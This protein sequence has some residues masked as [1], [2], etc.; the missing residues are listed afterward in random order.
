MDYLR[1]LGS[2]AVSTLVQKSGLN[3]PFTLGAKVA[4]FDTIYTLYDGTKRDDG[5]PVSIF[6]YE[7]SGRNTRALAQNAL[8]KL[9]TT[10]HPDV[11]KFMDVVETDSTIHIM[12]ERVRPLQ[13]ALSSW[14]TKTEQERQDWLLW[15]LHRVSVAL[16]FLNDP[17][18]STH[19]A[20]NTNAIFISP[21]GEW[22]LGG[23][24]LLSNPKDDAAV[25]YTSAS[26]LPGSMNTAPPEVK[27]SGWSTLK[28]HDV[29]AADA[30]ALGLL[31][32]TL[33]NPSHPP[34]A[35][36]QPPHPPPPASS[37][38]SI[39]LP[40]FPLFKK[41]LTPNPATR[42]T[43]KHF[44][45]VG[46]TDGGFFANNPLVKICLGLDNFAIASESEKAT[47]LR[48]LNESAASF[49]QELASKKILP[50]L[51]SAL[52]FGGAS[53]AAILP[54]VLQFGANVSPEEYTKTIVDPIVKLYSSPDRGTRM[55][56][57]DHLPQYID[58]L[59]KKTVSDKIFPHLQTGFADTVAVIREATV[60]SISSFAPKLTER[61]LNN[62]LLRLLAKMQVDPEPSIRT[63]TCILLGRL[64]PTLG[65]N[66]KKKVLVPAFSRALKD[67]F[68][69]ARVAALMAFTATIDCF[70][71]EDLA[72]KVI[73][74]MSFALIDRE[75]VV[76]DQAFKTLDLYVKKL[77]AHAAT[78]PETANTDGPPNLPELNT[79]SSTAIINSAAGAAT[80]LAGWA[81][82][83]LGK[84]LAASD[85]QTTIDTTSNP[86]DSPALTAKPP[87]P[88]A[89]RPAL[90]QTP[91]SSST[92]AK[93]LQLGG[94]KSP[95][96][97]FNLGDQL[98]EEFAASETASSWGGDLMDVNADDDDWSAFETAQAPPVEAPSTPATPAP[99]TQLKV[100]AP[101][102]SSLHRSS[103]PRIPTSARAPS[104]VTSRSMTP[105]QAW[106]SQGEWVEAPSA[107]PSAPPTPSV[108]STGSSTP[109]TKEEKAAEMA[110]RKE[111]RR[112]RIAML[113]EQKKLAAAGA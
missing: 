35:T 41:L 62:D 42:A 74:N 33:F 44:L 90:S 31:L 95:N 34:P 68:V 59:D 107:K 22:K 83:S 92:K 89:T 110:R 67:S 30:Y 63:N 18:S 7:L 94:M 50:S 71:I 113:K 17:C 99:V 105:D 29:A 85:M 1:T 97:A 37:R 108:S 75:K 81:I 98:A 4:T 80:T 49:P 100:K 101:R 106:D 109:M 48:T 24:E 69:H 16:T 14:S 72:T 91:S 43:P 26:L 86:L 5:S 3:L 79:T 51:L 93:P 61:I 55:A 56:L 27:K 40:I 2:A 96:S 45:E 78:L 66:T 53:A 32:H 36:A 28:Q 60:R 46:M 47:F 73:P 8:R 64:G 102:P 11:L 12:T 82:T 65:Y 15:G 10:R 57:L 6:E 111:E 76:R 87:V 84:Q 77:E 54:L 19:G 23:F 103:S 25:L 52:E 70:E 39:P 104:G 38:G 88:L 58:K 9:R 112:Q 21:S 20:F 13:S